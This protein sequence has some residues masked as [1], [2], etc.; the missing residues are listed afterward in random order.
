MQIS[1]SILVA[2]ATSG[3]SYVK[4]LVKNFKARVL[5]YPNS[6]FEAEP[7]LV[8]TL[9]ELNNIELLRQS[10]LVITPNAYNEGV[11]YDV[12]PNTPLGDMDVVRATTATRVNSAGLI[13]VVPRN[14][15]TYSE[16]FDNANWTK[17]ASITANATDAPNGFLTADKISEIAS[18]NFQNIFQSVAQNI[19]QYT[20]SI[21]L[22]KGQNDRCVLFA[23][24]S[25]A[26]LWIDM[27]NW[28]SFSQTNVNSYSI[29][30]VGNDWYRVQFTYTNTSSGNH[31]T[32]IN[33]V[34]I[35]TTNTVN[36]LGNTSNG[37]FIWGAQVEQG[38]TAT[39]YFPTTTRLNIPRIDYTNG[40]C[41]SLLVEPQRT[42]LFLRSEEFND[43]SWVKINANVTANDTISPSGVLNADK[44]I[45]TAV[46][47][48][49]VALQTATGSISGTTF[50]TSVFVKASGLSRIT[51]LNNQGGG[52]IVDYN[53]TT[54]TFTLT[55]GVSAS[56]QNYGNGWYRCIM[57]FIPNTT[58]LFNLQVRLADSSG[59]TTFTGN[60]VD[61]VSLWGFQVEQRTYPTSY[62]PTVASSVTRN[63]D[64]IS[65]TGISSLIGQTEGTVFLDFELLPNNINSSYVF[66]LNDGTTTNMIRSEIYILSPTVSQFRTGVNTLGVSQGDNFT[67][68]SQ[69]KNKMAIS[70][71]LNNLKIFINGT[72]VATDTSVTIPTMSA[73]NIGNRTL[74]NIIGSSFKQAILFKTQLTNAECI[75]LT[76]L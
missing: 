32:G 11:L 17:I 25:Q 45:A 73:F 67:T 44:L 40:S 63:A 2:N 18:S 7:C 9:T 43:T 33:L 60:G 29:N 61:G 49:H 65:K 30:A 48:I 24:S 34:Q 69:L 39:E 71:S 31:Q 26:L 37:M 6:I 21:Y 27:T 38:S 68:I 12:I 28:T 74:D 4:R 15:L 50:T 41:P 36:Y 72:L 22:K 58:G 47:G 64:L 66:A 8:A 16:Q 70:Y 20:Y 57:T 55:S 52:G 1:I 76:T 5:S 42:N 75:A 62:I 59:N 14:L 3:I 53:L 54:A 10:S 56:I 46:S 19:G 13:E 35:G 23:G 51:L